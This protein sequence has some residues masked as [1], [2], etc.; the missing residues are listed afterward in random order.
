MGASRVPKEDVVDHLPWNHAHHLL[1]HV[2]TDA[3]VTRPVEVHPPVETETADDADHGHHQARAPRR[4][5]EAV[6]AVTVEDR[7]AH[8]HHPMT[9]E[10]KDVLT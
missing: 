2:K 3:A 8:L 9:T 6:E 5:D 4:G 1:D 7:D 10:A